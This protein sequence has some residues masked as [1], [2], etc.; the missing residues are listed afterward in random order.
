MIT[1]TNNKVKQ[2]G[3]LPD[4]VYKKKVVDLY[5]SSFQY[6]YSSVGRIFKITSQRVGQIHKEYKHDCPRANKAQM[7]NP[8]ISKE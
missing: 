5:D 6:S 8:E 3:P 7:I 1:Q 2:N 4:L